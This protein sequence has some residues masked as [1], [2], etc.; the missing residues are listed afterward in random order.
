MLDAFTELAGGLDHPEG[1]AWAPD[2]ALYAGGEAGQVYRIGLDGSVAQ[3]AST[4][5]F[6]YG[7]AVDGASTVYAC[8]FGNAAVARISAAGDVSVLS[9]WNPRSPD[10]RSQ[11]GSV[12]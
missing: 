9:L 10:A 11:R 1:I 8:D 12:R 3:I 7:L 6:M 2:G 5:G 4:E